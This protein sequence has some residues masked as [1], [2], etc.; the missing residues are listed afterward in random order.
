MNNQLKVA[1]ADFPPLVLSHANT[2]EGFE[3][4]LWNAIAKE[5]NVDFA[6]EHHA[7]KDI[8]PL[9]AERKVDIGLAGITINEHR[10]KLID[11]S[12]P[13]LNSGL[14]ISVNRNK[15][16]PSL[17]KTLKIIFTQGNK[18]IKS[19]FVSVMLFIFV[20]GNLLW[21]VEKGAGTFSKD[22]FPGIFESFWLVIC[23]MSTDSFGDY[24]PQTWTGRFITSLIII[25]GVAIFGLLIA[26]ITAFLAV[27]RVQGEINTSRDLVGKKVGTV[28]GSTSQILLKK[29][30]AGVAGFSNIDDAYTELKQEQLDAVVFDAPAVIYYQEEDKANAIETVGELFDKQSYGIALQDGSPWREK[31]N[32]ALLK[33]KES[34][35]YDA[36]YKRWF[37]EDLSMEI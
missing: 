29:I 3:I 20:F 16:K 6:L 19:A 23:T 36:C 11:F 14:L 18:I 28:E 35:K 13:T 4:D 7:F 26:Q 34:G 25:G 33:I 5:M 2:Y 37:G 22:Y 31:I 17:L 32:Q 1:I 8:I 9:L 30:G 10:E 21:F 15:N 24:V 27:K 12:H